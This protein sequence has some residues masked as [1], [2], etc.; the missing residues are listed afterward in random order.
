MVKLLDKFVVYVS[1][2]SIA[3]P[4]WTLVIV[5]CGFCI[6]TSCGGYAGSAAAPESPT[7]QSISV[8]PQNDTVAAGLTQQYTA[9]GVYSDGS[10]KPMSGVSWTTSNTAIATITSAGLLTGLKKGVL[11]VTAAS[12]AI[13]GSTPLTIGAPNLSSIAVSPQNPTISAGQIQQFAATGTYSDGSTQTLNGASWSSGT[14]TVATITS[15][16]LATSLSAGT[17]LIQA[18]SGNTTGSTTLTITA[19]SK[20]LTYIAGQ[21]LSSGIGHPEGVVVADFNG[22]GKPDIAVSNFDTNTVAV[23]LNDGT[24]HFSAPIVTAVQLTSSQGLNVGSLAVGD[25]NEDGKPDLVVATI[26]GS[27]VSIVLLGNGDGT[28]R[29]QPPI[30]N[31]FGFLR[32]KVVDL[33]GD[34][35]QDL[36]F[37]MNGSL[38][39]SL[40]K[41]DGTFGAMTAL[42]SG[43]FPGLYLGLTV[44]DFNGDGKLDIAASDFGS[45]TGG[46]GTLVFYAGK[47]D[48]TFANPS[49]TTLA[50]ASFPGSLASGDFNNDG[51]QDVLIGFPNIAVVSFGNGDGTFD[52]AQSSFEFVYGGNFPTPTTNSVT[53]FAT[54]LTKDG[55]SDA[56]TSDFDT[57]TLQIALNSAL[58]KAP[59]SPGIFSFSLA[60]GLAD[61]AAGDLNGDGVLDVVVIN[62][63]TS[64]IDVV[65]SKQ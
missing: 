27:Q 25:F 23:F 36:V 21:T 2:R 65:L 31:S 13:T 44:A 11:T 35:H 55:K 15:G 12:G 32:A 5:L 62:Y 60:P 53:V 26:A 7:L 29:Q 51:K 49:A 37:A 10:S 9:T 50:F 61:I 63:K 8:S 46:F 39:V 45:V 20:A 16:G 14:A 3:E 22:D 56:V 34:G 17:T 42:P 57:G 1:A 24:G 4:I 19:A 59:P 33:N 41:G 38:G 28:F 48:G 18:T 40:G 58:G 54:D 64:E 6:L 52:L 30:A 43:S 47:G